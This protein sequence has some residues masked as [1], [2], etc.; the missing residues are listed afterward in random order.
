MKRKLFSAVL[1]MV[2]ATMSITTVQ[3]TEM[4]EPSVEAEEIIGVSA[5]DMVVSENTK[6]TQDKVVTGDLY[7]KAPLD[8]NGFNLQVKGDVYAEA[9]V[10]VDSGE[11]LTVAGNYMQKARYLEV[12]GGIVT[13]GG[14]LGVYDTDTAG[15]RVMGTGC[16]RLFTT[17]SAVTI[18]GDMILNTDCL[19]GMTYGGY[20]KGIFTLKGDLI[21]EHAGTGF[22]PQNLILAGTGEQTL[23][24]LN[25]VNIGKLQ[26]TNGAKIQVTDYFNAGLGSDVTLVAKNGTVRTSFISL[27]GNKLQVNGNVQA[28]GD[29]YVQD[30]AKL[31]VTG[32]YMQKTEQLEMKS[33]TVAITGDL[34]LYSLDDAGKKIRGNG[35]IILASKDSAISIDG[36]MI[37][38]TECVNGMWHNSYTAGTITL[39]GDLIQEHSGVGFISQNLI[40]AGTEEQTLTLL[41]ESFLGNL[42]V[43]NNVSV[44]VTEWFNAGLGSD[45]SV[46]TT[47]EEWSIRTNQLILNGKELN[48]NGN[49]LAEGDVKVGSGTLKVKGSHWQMIGG[50]LIT[51]GHVNVSKDLLIQNVDENGKPITGE[52]YLEIKDQNGFLKVGGSMLLNTTSNMYH[53][54]NGKI[55]IRKDLIQE[56]AEARFR[57]AYIYMEGAGAQK[58][59]FA[60]ANA[61]I[62]TLELGQHIS[63]YTFNPNPC[64]NTLIEVE[65]PFSDV[66]V[67]GWEFPYV[68]YALDY[69]LMGGKGT[70]NDGKVMFDPG[71]NMTRAEFVQALYNKEGKPAVTYSNVFTDVPDGKWFTNAIMW[72]Y[73]NDIV[74][75]KA[76]KFD[77]SGNITREEMATIL[78]KYAANYKKYEVAVG[79]SLD[80]YTDAS[81]ISS[82]A[83]KN[84]EWAIWCGV[85]KGKGTMIAP[86]DFATRAECA[87]MLR[88]FIMAYED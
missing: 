80:E 42:Q 52:G 17:D 18:D 85:M 53:Y 67:K 49:F 26:V 54:V 78:Y 27:N 66:N 31:T 45:V 60:S 28:E 44:R 58:I 62:G 36:D 4:K 68:K 37:M 29:V 39:K 65:N 35:H 55:L 6:L 13:I 14:N 9:D 74:K 64:W 1:V 87:T 24:L 33:G 46:V 56:P 48:V 41:P 88:N 32:N 72:A 86:R 19:N 38:D 30:G 2:L 75:G 70:D 43:K 73:Q 7:V 50:L 16:V 63:K 69:N 10:F 51:D 22:K 23:S 20:T 34:L 76:D 11:K 83:T 40:L 21:E 71:K 25:D 79:A 81:T 57:P 15:K 61:Q 59:S 47:T 3:A 82:W 84:I 12:N 5:T 77:V 8:L